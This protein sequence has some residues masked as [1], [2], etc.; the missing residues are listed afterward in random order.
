MNNYDRDPAAN[1]DVND[2][3]ERHKKVMTHHRN[4]DAPPEDY[5]TFKGDVRKLA[6][7]ST[8]LACLSAKNILRLARMVGIH[9]NGDSHVFLA[10]C[11]T[12]VKTHEK[13]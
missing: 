5:A 4:F 11:S 9:I 3:W 13:D 12:A 1:K 7:N 2:L 6:T 8:L 10:A